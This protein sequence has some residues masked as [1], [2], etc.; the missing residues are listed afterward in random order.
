MIF[1]GTGMV[2]RGDEI[3]QYG[4]GFRS[5]H[6]DVAALKKQ[7]DGIIL[8]YVQ[9]VD[10]F[11]SLDLADGGGRAVTE[12]VTVDGPALL[13]NVDT[14]G[15]G[16][17]RVGLR[18]DKGEEIPGF[19]VDECAVM[20]TSAAGALVRWGEKG[21]SDLSASAG[22]PCDWRLMEAARSSS[23]SASTKRQQRDDE[24]WRR[25]GYGSRANSHESAS[26]RVSSGPAGSCRPFAP[27]GTIAASAAGSTAVRSPA[28]DSVLGHRAGG[29]V[30]VEVGMLQ[31][32]E[33]VHPDL[34]GGGRQRVV[35]AD[36][37]VVEE[38]LGAE[39]L[40]GRDPRVVPRRRH[41]R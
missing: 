14:S 31:P 2:V 8:R 11:V 28:F 25:R 40:R 36:V 23:A 3:W 9:R 33:R 22:K 12:P 4:T 39:V 15:L 17:L 16:G 6:G 26:P 29:R 13:L 27:P 37:V 38:P 35:G 34:R 30:R 18:S 19:G 10:G 5:R 41:R 32:H 21:T 24:K 1:I 20:H 7:A